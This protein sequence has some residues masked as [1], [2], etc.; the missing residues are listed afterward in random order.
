MIVPHPGIEP[1]PRP[2]KG[3]ILTDRLIGMDVVLATPLLV[4]D[5]TTHLYKHY[6]TNKSH[7]SDGQII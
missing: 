5:W 6:I 1:G 7:D 4:S 2:W 3:H